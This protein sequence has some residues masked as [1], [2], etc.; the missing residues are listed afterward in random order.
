MPSFKYF[1]EIFAFS[2]LKWTHLRHLTMFSRFLWRSLKI[3][4]LNIYDRIYKSSWR[5]C[6]TLCYFFSEMNK[7]KISNDLFRFCMHVDSHVL[8]C[9]I[10]YHFCNSKNVKNTHGGVL[11]L[12]KLQAKPE[13]LSHRRNLWIYLSVPHHNVLVTLCKWGRL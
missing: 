5:I 13:R 8:R 3:C 4:R 10:W 9:A 12:V 7:L 6:K 1:L 2:L 11:L